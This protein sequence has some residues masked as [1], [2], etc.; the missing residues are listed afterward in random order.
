MSLPL[1]Q[2]KKNHPNVPFLHENSQLLTAASFVAPSSWPV[3]TVT[4]ILYILV[5]F[6]LQLQPI[7]LS[8]STI[9]IKSFLEICNISHEWCLSLHISSVKWGQRLDTVLKSAWCFLVW[10]ATCF[11]TSCRRKLFLIFIPYTPTALCWE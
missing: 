6:Q 3:L 4:G 10:R 7:G 11:L 8:D 9:A 2:G 5:L 1:G